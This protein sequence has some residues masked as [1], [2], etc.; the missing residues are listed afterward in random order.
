MG[1]LIMRSQAPLILLSLVVLSP[2]LAQQAPLPQHLYKCKDASGRVYYTQVPPR[3]CLGRDTLELN[4][5]GT[6]V[7]ETGRAPTAAESKAREAE[8]KKQAEA[9]EKDKEERRKNTALLNTY[10][11]EKD[12][13]DQ[14]ARALKEAQTAIEDTE[15]HI[16]GLQKRQKDL[17]A[18][19]EFYVKKPIPPKVRQEIS[20]NEIEIKNQTTLLESKKSEISQINAKY[21]EDKRR[22]VELTT[23]KK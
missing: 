18:E 1:W 10:A 20:N 9:A 17:E 7:K 21:D 3:E 13:E 22:Y 16:A 14:R 2:A 19:K 8:R 15:K 23:G 11:S 5:S 4:K 12:I 6:V